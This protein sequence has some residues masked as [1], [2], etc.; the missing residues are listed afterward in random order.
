[1]G[2]LGSILSVLLILFFFDDNESILIIALIYFCF[3]LSLFT[4]YM[5]YALS[6]ILSVR[7]ED[8][9]VNRS[10]NILY[11]AIEVHKI[12]YEVH[13]LIQAKRPIL[14]EFEFQFGWTGS[15]FPKISSD[16]QVIGPIVEE[17]DSA[18]SDK[19]I[20]KFKKPLFY[21]ET[22]VIHFKA[23]MNDADLK[24]LPLVANN[25]T[26]PIDLIHFRIVLRYKKPDF[27]GCATLTRRKIG[28]VREEFEP[29]KSIAFD[30]ET[31]SFETR[32]LNPEVNY[33]YRISWD[34]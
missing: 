32:L 20:L 7:N 22:H 29:M 31:K 12:N 10:T 18:K 19:A 17:N 15:E 26:R 11:E 8:D 1:L 4:G 25:V 5:M 16:I 24:S 30:K 2:A 9:H 21:N 6:K 33:Q 14:S 23:E 28:S 34:R 3:V 27:N 13:K